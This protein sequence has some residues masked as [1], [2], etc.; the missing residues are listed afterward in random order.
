MK[1][2]A[3]DVLRFPFFLHFFKIEKHMRMLSVTIHGIVTD[4]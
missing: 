1:R 3:Y 4:I 2:P